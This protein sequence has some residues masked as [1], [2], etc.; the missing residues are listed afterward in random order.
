MK[1]QDKLDKTSNGEIF[2]MCAS[3]NFAIYATVMTKHDVNDIL[4]TVKSGT[5]VITKY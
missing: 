4:V 3:V 2:R 1:I 5:Y